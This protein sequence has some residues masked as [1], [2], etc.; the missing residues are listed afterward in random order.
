MVGV[1]PAILGTPESRIVEIFNYGRARQGTIPLWVGEGDQPTARF[2]CEAAEQ[3]LRDGQTFYTYQR[4]IPPLRQALADYLN[5]QFRADVSDERVIVT[6]SGMQALHLTAELLLD[7]GDE[8]VMVMPVWPNIAAAVTLMGG[9]LRPVPLRMQEGRWHLDLDELFAN[10]G[11]RTK[12][13]FINSPSNPTGWVMDGEDMDRVVEFVRH[14]GLWLLS[15]EVYGRLV[16]DGRPQES[17]LSRMEP[18]ERLIVINSFSKNWQMTGWRVGWA[19]IPPSL[20][21]L[22][23]NL[24]QYNTSGVAEFMQ[25]AALVAITQGEPLVR[26][27]VA[28]CEAGRD[29]VVERLGAVPR[30]RL[31]RP[32]G[33]FYAFFAVEGEPDSLALAKRLVD[34]AGVGL[35]PGVAFGEAGEGF[36]R[37]CFAISPAKLAEALDRLA[38]ALA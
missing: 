24:V 5:T 10:C 30:V 35:A 3:S 11:P 2:I 20:G 33:A 7:P 27:I 29:M 15:D 28:Q 22:W 1:R 13:L 36:Q 14:R 8:V 16:F 25:R 26:S 12:A 21:Q 6:G 38:T 18:E 17:F 32:E 9:V 4:G 31:A 37:M 23:E 19:V 34:E